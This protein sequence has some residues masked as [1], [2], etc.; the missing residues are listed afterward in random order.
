VDNP[1]ST[2]ETVPQFSTFGG[3][4]VSEIL[5]ERSNSICKVNS[6]KS[7][8]DYSA[9][10]EE[11]LIV[12]IIKDVVYPFL[13]SKNA[14][15][16]DGFHLFAAIGFLHEFVIKSVA[17]LFVLGGPD[18]GFGGVGEIAAGEVGRR[19][20]LN[21]RDVVE[22]LKI[23]LLHSEADTVDDVG[24]AGDPDGAVGFEDALACG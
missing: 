10:W 8:R 2:P 14:H 9:A 23:E 4:F 15:F 13:H 19:I 20:G 17:G 11:F 1:Q 24:G 7:T 16:P 18:D 5:Q 3:F 6:F 12:R 22:E 21:P